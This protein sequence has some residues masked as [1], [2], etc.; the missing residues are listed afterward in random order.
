[1][2]MTELSESA[3]KRWRLLPDEAKLP[4]IRLE[5]DDKVRAAREVTATRY[6]YV[7]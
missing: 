1:M 5:N 3:A 2:S 7:C 4:F 6:V